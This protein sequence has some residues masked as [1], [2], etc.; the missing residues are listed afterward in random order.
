MGGLFCRCFHADAQHVQPEANLAGLTALVTGV[1][2]GGLGFESALQLARR[3]ARVVFTGR[4]QA[5]LD[6]AHRALVSALGESAAAA[7]L[8]PMRLDVSDLASVDSFVHAFRRSKLQLNLLLHNAGILCPRGGRALS[9][10][11][12]ELTLATNY[13]GA[14][15]L[16]QRLLPD[17]LRASAEQRRLHGAQRAYVSRVVHVSSRAH[18]LSSLPLNTHRL[19]SYFTP[20]PEFY[21]GWDS[22]AHSKL[23][24][25]LHAAHLSRLYDPT[26]QLQAFSV[27]PGVVGTSIGGERYLRALCCLCTPCF[28]SVQQGAAT[29]VYLA[30]APSNELAQHSGEYFAACRPKRLSSSVTEPEVARAVWEHTLQIVREWSDARSVEQEL[31]QIDATDAPLPHAAT[32]LAGQEPA[33]TEKQQLLS[34]SSAASSRMDSPAG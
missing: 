13:L 25:I 20:K 2:V 1:S 30:C 19:G 33:D 27:H 31:E 6:A 26:T 21:D 12:V 3:G 28:K 10:Q 11:G 22:Y 5:R 9:R 23:C 15:Y 17:L 24:Q 29:G 16:T 18:E 34:P 8:K 4:N 7:Q 32:V 14:F